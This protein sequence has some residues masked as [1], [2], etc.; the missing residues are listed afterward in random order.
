ME[1]EAE[2]PD[3]AALVGAARDVGFPLV[4]KP[5]DTIDIEVWGQPER[6]TLL[7]TLEF[8]SSRKPMRVII[9]ALVGRI[10]LYCRGAD[11]AIHQRLSANV[12]PPLKEKTTR[13]W[14]HSQMEVRGRCVSHMGS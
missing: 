7:N 12:D 11:T 10:I 2:S 13:T 8:N 14:T 4:G 5:R 3:E 6:H 9:R 1:Y